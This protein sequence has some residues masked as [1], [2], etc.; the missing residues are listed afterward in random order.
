MW[1]NRWRS[2]FWVGADVR[3]AFADGAFDRFRE[4]IAGCL[5][6]RYPWPFNYLLFLAISI[7]N[8]VILKCA[9]RLNLVNS[10]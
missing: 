2:A 5:R 6:H 7:S 9:R 1:T 3:A 4:F 10:L 8:D